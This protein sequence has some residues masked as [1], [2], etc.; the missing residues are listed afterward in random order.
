MKVDWKDIKIK[1]I[2]GLVCQKLKD[3]G[4]DTVLTG[5]ACVT[6]YSN[7]KYISGDL[8]FV[9]YFNLK[10]IVPVLKALGLTKK[11]TRHF[12]NPKCPFFI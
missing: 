1:D 5:G 12:E 9:T 3:K 4:I 8:D 11:G 2:A 6:I 10:N 7:N